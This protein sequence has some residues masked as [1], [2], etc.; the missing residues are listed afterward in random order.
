LIPGAVVTDTAGP[1]GAATP[2]GAAAALPFLA[3]LPPWAP[4]V[5]GA[6]VLLV[7]VGIAG[8]A[9]QRSQ[10]AEEEEEDEEED[11]ESEEP[12]EEGE[13]EEGEAVDDEGTVEAPTREEL[14]Q[15]IADLDDAYEAGDMTAGD[16]KRRRAALKAQLAELGRNDRD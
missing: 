2:T 1:G 14:L 7:I 3:S 15:A 4:Y 10:G 6:A 13:G 16:Y 5:L 9:W 8:W 11:E 12:G